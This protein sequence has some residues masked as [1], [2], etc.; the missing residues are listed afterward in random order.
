MTTQPLIPTTCCPCSLPP[1]ADYV[2]ACC[3]AQACCPGMAAAPILAALAMHAHPL[4]TAAGDHRTATPAAAN[5][6]LLLHIGTPKSNLYPS[7]LSGMT[8]SV[9]ACVNLHRCSPAAGTSVPALL[10]LLLAQWRCCCCIVR[11]GPVTCARC[12]C[13]APLALLCR[14]LALALLKLCKCCCL[15]Q[16]CR[17][18]ACL[19]EL[20]A[21]P[22]H[23]VG[24]Q[25]ICTAV[26]PLLPLLLMLLLLDGR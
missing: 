23:T 14:Q 25:C 10:L 18:S 1:A 13:V 17:R 9:G 7:Q 2:E 26:P 21:P 6:G 8:T 11:P 16:R 24:H 5:L 12:C 3:R 19:Q 20:M 15:C 22:T 4:S